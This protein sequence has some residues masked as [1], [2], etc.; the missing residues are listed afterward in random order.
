MSGSFP[1]EDPDAIPTD[2]EGD[3][4]SGPRTSPSPTNPTSALFGG[5]DEGT[6]P[7]RST[8]DAPATRVLPLD[9]MPSPSP[10]LGSPGSGVFWDTV[11][12]GGEFQPGQFI[13]NRYIVQGKLGRGGMG[14][15]WLVTHRELNTPRA[16]KLIVAGIS[17]DAQA[18]ARFRREAQVMA[19]FSH[20]NAVIVHDARL[21]ERDVAF[22]DMEY[23][24]GQSLD[25]VV[26]RGQPMPLPWVARVLSQLCDVLDVAH[27]RGIVHRDLK[28]ANLMLLD[29][30]P[31]GKEHLK[32]LDF[33]IAKILRE[34]ETEGAPHTMTGMFL[35]T[36]PYASPEQADGD[37]DI[38]S[39]IYSVGVILYEFLTGFRPFSGPAARLLVDTISTPAPRFSAVNAKVACPPEIEGLVLRCLA[40][41]P[42]HRP[43]SAKALA[44]E[45]H[46]LAPRSAGD[47]VSIAAVPSSSKRAY[48]IAGAAVLLLLIAVFWAARRMGPPEVPG[49]GGES[50]PAAPA[51]FAAA[52]DAKIDDRGR[53][54]ILVPTGP[55]AGSG[56][57]LIVLEGGTLAPED[58][59]GEP[60]AV[61]SFAMSE[62]EVTNGQMR[63]YFRDRKIEPPRIFEDA[64]SKL[65]NNE[66][67]KVPPAD[68]E[69][70]P[71]VGISKAMAE[72]FAR[73]AGGELPTEPQWAYASRSQ[74]Q[75]DRRFVWKDNS[76]A[77]S[78]GGRANLD[79]VE[80]LP[81]RTAKA[82]N[83]P[84]DR[85]D[86]GIYD[87]TG[88][89]REWCRDPK[90]ARG[91]S[92]VRGGSYLTFATDYTNGLRQ[93]LPEAPELDDV[94]FRIVVNWPSP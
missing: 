52:P 7:L 83:Y 86:Q 75:P 41:D 12:S 65:L 45:F 16:I 51:N 54:T 23:I 8:E 84:D 48:L 50:P 46:A 77:V 19:S 80:S 42:T 58:G 78:N 10:D 47:V 2:I 88:N 53:P 40:K 61:P 72:D 25:R 68:A 63:A 20:P 87:L 30:C 56:F 55:L 31:P 82:K 28:P 13:F 33:G 1:P 32:V 38:R 67:A 6:A 76:P 36:P 89:V 5:T 93:M 81:T 74:G 90:A 66:T 14:T 15:V 34:V 21:T 27:D 17:F 69:R 18:R 11:E 62:T 64:I 37:A 60:I 22:I 4:P 70:H 92:V 94:G 39:D 29:G 44:E 73:W 49:A 57:R 79:T 91:M 43:Q 35:G 71:A 9:Q 3:S 24:Q 59:L 26:T 85:T